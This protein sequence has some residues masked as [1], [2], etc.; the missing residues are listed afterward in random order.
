MGIYLNPDNEKFYQAIHSEIYVD[1]TKLLAYTNALMRTSQKYLC[2]SR[3]R[4]FG[5]SMAAAMLAAYYSRGCDSREMFE[6]LKIGKAKSFLE[7]LNRYDV[8][9][10]NMQEFL[11]QSSS[12]EE[13]LS[14]LKRSVL[15]ELLDEYPDYR[16]F[17]SNNLVRTMQDIHKNTKHPFIVIINEWDCVFREY[18]MHKEEQDQYLDFLRDMLKDKGYIYLAYMTGILPIKKYGTHSDL[19]MFDEYSMTNPDIL[20]EFV[21]FTQTEVKELCAR[22]G[23]NMEEIRDWYDGYQFEKEASVYAPRSVVRAVTSGICDAYWNQTETFEAL[24]AYIDMNLEGLKDDVL[25]MMSGERVRINVGNFSNDMVTFHTKDDVLT[26]LVHLGYLGYDFDDEC[27]FIPNNEIRK[28]FFNA[29]SV[30][31]WGEVSRIFGAA[32]TPCPQSPFPSGIPSQQCKSSA[33]YIV[34]ARLCSLGRSRRCI[35]YARSQNAPAQ[36]PWPPAFRAPPRLLRASPRNF[37]KP[38]DKETREHECVIEEFVK[39]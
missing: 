9:M 20:A 36:C 25:S 23:R 4:R 22:Y 35:G 18:K 16:Y 31:D 14:L 26:L 8:L 19:N 11:S 39:V 6:G 1:K 33:P 15:W 3:P 37:S 30:S 24:R 10:L 29:V 7:H 2:V 38:Y 17:D 12:M 27:V 28:E 13:M 32:D 21:G 34:R 5:K